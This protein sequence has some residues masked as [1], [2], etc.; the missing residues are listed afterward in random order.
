MR[1]FIPP[2]LGRLLVLYGIG[3]RMGAQLQP[4]A[5]EPGKQ[6]FRCFM[7]RMPLKHDSRSIA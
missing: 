5:V 1:M 2:N 7:K 6:P 4:I 3:N